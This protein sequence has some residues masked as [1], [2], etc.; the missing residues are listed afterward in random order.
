MRFAQG[1]ALDKVASHSRQAIK[2]D[3]KQD[4]LHIKRSSN[5][6]NKKIIV[7]KRSM[8]VIKKIIIADKRSMNAHKGSMNGNKKKIIF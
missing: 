1:R 5:L 8:N 2:P 3:N 4:N 6:I 7:E